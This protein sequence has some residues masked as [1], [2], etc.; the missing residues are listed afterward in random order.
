MKR[1]YLRRRGWSTSVTLDPVF[2]MFRIAPPNELRVN[3]RP[4]M[5]RTSLIQIALAGGGAVL[6]CICED[7]QQVQQQAQRTL[8]A[9]LPTP[10]PGGWWEDEG[11][12]GEA[13]IV[14]HLSE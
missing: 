9:V 11:A 14:V 10:T 2:S 4:L 6:F 7:M 13:R 3:I 1:A 12:H 5:K 8:S